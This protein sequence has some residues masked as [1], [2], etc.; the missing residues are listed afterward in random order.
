VSPWRPAAASAAPQQ[1][2]GETVQ[3]ALQRGV[4]RLAAAGVETPRLDAELLLAYSLGARRLDLYAY[5][6]RLLL[7]E[8]RSRWEALVARRARREPLPYIIEEIEFFGLSFRVGPG[9]LIPRPETELL[10]E[11]VLEY[12][13]GCPAHP[14]ILDVGTGSGCIALAL[15]SRLP[16]ARIVALD[17]S[18]AAL[19]LARENGERLG[20]VGRVQWIAGAW[21]RSERYDVIAANPPYIPSGELQNLA[22]ELKEHEPQIALDGGP[23]GLDLI[24]PLLAEAPERLTPGGLLAMEMAAGQGETVLALARA[25]AEWERLQ[26]RPDLAGIPRVLLATRR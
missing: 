6:E 9:V 13:A 8:E 4:A 2:P 23:D 26:I 1:A 12:A 11:A 24:R 21:P 25:V 20:L 5:P 3:I 17:P 15:A 22:P 14:A 16:Q 18:P 7:P 10:V 19:A